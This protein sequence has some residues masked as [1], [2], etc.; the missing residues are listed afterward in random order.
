MP[1]SLILSLLKRV[2]PID[3]PEILVEVE[4]ESLNPIYLSFK[5]RFK[6][7]D[8]H[9][10]SINALFVVMT[11]LLKMVNSTEINVISAVIV[12]NHLANKLKHQ[13]LI[14]RKK[15]KY[16]LIILNA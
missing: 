16:G 6:K 5:M 3:L 1:K 13:L 15:Q 7:P 8:I 4:K 10:G 11:I 9:Q 2:A 12:A 14:Q